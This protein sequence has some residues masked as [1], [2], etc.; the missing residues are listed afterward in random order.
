M[1]SNPS[2]RITDK[3]ASRSDF[4]AVTLLDPNNGSFTVCY[5][6]DAPFKLKEIKA[7]TD[8]GTCTLQVGKS[9]GSVGDPYSVNS[10][11]SI[12]NP[13]SLDNSYVKA[14]DYV[15]LALSSVSGSPTKLFIQIDIEWVRDEDGESA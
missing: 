11:T 12:N 1:P 3:Q 6:P 15:T 14:T 5:K 9:G 10:S 4:M 7:Q 13:E 2:W 8:T